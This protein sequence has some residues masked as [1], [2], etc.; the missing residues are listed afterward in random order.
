MISPGIEKKKKK[1]I[2]MISS[3]FEKNAPTGAKTKSQSRLYRNLGYM[4][5]C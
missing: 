5:N 4:V 3:Y 1:K 2:R